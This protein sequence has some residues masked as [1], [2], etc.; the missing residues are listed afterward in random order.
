MLVTWFDGHA[1]RRRHIS[2]RWGCWILRWDPNI[3]RNVVGASIVI[4]GDSPAQHKLLALPTIVLDCKH[5]SGDQLNITATTQNDIKTAARCHACLLNDSIT[6]SKPTCSNKPCQIRPQSI[7]VSG[8]L[9]HGCAPS[10]VAPHLHRNQLCGHHGSCI[11]WRT[12]RSRLQPWL[13]LGRQS[14]GEG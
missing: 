9:D 13:A 8:C 10:V 12:I 4:D 6:G 2:L 7:V 14:P 5:A 1:C 11:V 3:N